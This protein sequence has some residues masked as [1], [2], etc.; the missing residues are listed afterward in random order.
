MLHLL[1][2]EILLNTEVPFDEQPLATSFESETRPEL[3]PVKKLRGGSGVP[4][5]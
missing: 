5:G 2:L 1:V 3:G 4:I